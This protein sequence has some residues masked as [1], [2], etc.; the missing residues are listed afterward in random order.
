MPH[1]AVAT[2]GPL[3]TG[4]RAVVTGG[5]AGIGA[6]V[7]VSLATHGAEVL[8]ADI[9][10]G[11]PLVFDRSAGG[12]IDTLGW[13]VTT[14]PVAVELVD[15]RPDILVNNV[16]H[17]VRPPRP[18]TDDRPEMWAELHDINVGHVLSLTHAVLPGMAERGRGS[19]INLTTV[20]AHR[21]IPGHTVYSANKAALMQF[22][23]S[24]AAE[25]GPSGVRV[26]AIAPDLIETVQVPY[27]DIVPA[28]DRALWPTWSP[29]GGPGSPE[30]V[31]GAALFLASDLARFV[32]GS[33]IHVDGGTH[34]SGGWVP[35]ASGGWTNRPRNP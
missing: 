23:R 18:F 19:I 13:D 32:T 2:P 26:N 1:Q 30:D 29:L 14:R 10:F 20:E 22:T 8:V 11:Q 33:T 3:L 12:S 34:G 15:H 27:A 28:E 16:G 21:A 9:A 6:A 35:R 25:V 5:A 7:A 4:R 17:F 24:L 31:A